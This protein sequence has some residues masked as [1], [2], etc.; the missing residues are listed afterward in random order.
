MVKF[1]EN[2]KYYRRIYYINKIDIKNEHFD[3]FNAKLYR[4][5][6]TSLKAYI[7]PIKGFNQKLHEISNLTVFYNSEYNVDTYTELHVKESNLGTFQVSYYSN[8]QEIA[9]E[10]TKDTF[11]TA[12]EYQEQEDSDSVLSSYPIFQ[13]K[14][15]NWGGIA[16]CLGISWSVGAVL[17][18]VCGTACVL[19]A[20]T[21]CVICIGAYLGFDIASIT[22]CIAGNT[23]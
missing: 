2:W 13:T 14:G 19:S 17:A 11:I 18:A 6:N 12:K 10:I 4:V 3:Y 23:V 5:N 9:N 21:A 7:I 1:T 16:K 8:G 22:G 20:G 15:V